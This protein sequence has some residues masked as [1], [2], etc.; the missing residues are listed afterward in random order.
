MDDQG[1]KQMTVSGLAVDPTTKAPI[2]VL[3]DEAETVTL[4]IW[5]A[6]PEAT[7]LAA[8]LD[9]VQLERPSTTDLLHQLVIESGLVVEKVTLTELRKSTFVA[10]IEFHAAGGSKQLECRPSDAISLALKAGCPIFVA[11]EL[12]QAVSA[13]DQAEDLAAMAPAPSNSEWP[14]SP[15]LSEVAPDEWERILEDL[16]PDD[17]KYKM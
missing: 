14:D 16:D 1:F 17:F 15:D 9:G 7:A 6:L 2:L 12:L 13:G 8:I 5:L 3:K 10:T 4:P 11:E